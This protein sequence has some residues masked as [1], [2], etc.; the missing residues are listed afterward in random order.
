MDDRNAKRPGD[1][2]NQGKIEREKEAPRAT[3]SFS[4][5]AT[6]TDQ[7]FIGHFAGATATASG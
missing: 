1:N 5:F 2:I 4:F 6:G 3:R 7:A